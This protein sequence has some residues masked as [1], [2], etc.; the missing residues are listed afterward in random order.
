MA[1]AGAVVPA[2][3]VSDV[4]L[5][6]ST[7]GGINW[8]SSRVNQDAAGNGKYQYMPA[9]RVDEY[10][11]VNINYYD[12]RNIPTN[13]SAQIYVSRSIDGGS[14]WSDILVS[15][16]KFKPKPISGLAGGYQGDYIGIT[17]G[18]GKIWPYW[19][20][21]ITG[22]YQAWI[23]SIDIGPAITHTALS[24]TEQLTG[25]Y[26]V[27]CVITPSGS[28][29]NPSKTKLFWSRNNPAITDSLLMTNTSGTNW[30]AN[31]PAN[32]SPATYRYYIS[33]TDSLNRKATAPSGAPSVLNSFVAS[34]DN[35]SPVITHTPLGDQAKPIW[36]STV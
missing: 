6:K 33:T 15:D 22:A 5:H 36:P 3:D 29:I 7:N 19:A 24:N 10:G 11:G 21:D 1:A 8:T 32:G 9:V 30:T 23:A 18:N 12:T 34:T 28:G 14:T 35:T 25:V 13:D 31:I 2:T 27:N 16:H 4:I 20:E 26:P 17:S